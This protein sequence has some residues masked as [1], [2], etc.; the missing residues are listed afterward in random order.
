MSAYSCTCSEQGRAP[1]WCLPKS[2]PLPR[3]PAHQRLRGYRRGH[4]GL[5]QRGCLEGVHG[6]PFTLLQDRVQEQGTVLLCLGPGVRSQ[7]RPGGKEASCLP[8]CQS[9]N[10]VL[11]MQTVPKP[12][13][14]C[15]LLYPCLVH[16]VLCGG[17]GWEGR[18]GRG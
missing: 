2:C 14:K 17:G 7:M 11:R 6:G 4:L 12:H 8:R 1:A 16:S 10:R 5:V 18:E 15:C 9:R 13:L 3:I